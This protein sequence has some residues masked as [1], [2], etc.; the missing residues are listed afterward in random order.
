MPI[1]LGMLVLFFGYLAY[2]LFRLLRF[3]WKGLDRSLDTLV[4]PAAE[5][6]TPERKP[7][8]T[9]WRPKS[10]LI[11]SSDSPLPEPSRPLRSPELSRRTQVSE[12]QPVFLEVNAPEAAPPLTPPLTPPATAT[13]KALV[14]PSSSEE[15]SPQVTPQIVDAPQPPTAVEPS[16][17]P[18]SVSILS[19]QAAEP[20]A[21]LPL[22]PSG[23]VRDSEA[24]PALPATDLKIT[25]AALPPSETISPQVSP[26]AVIDPQPL[27]PPA[28]EPSAA[29][30]TPSIPSPPLEVAPAPPP[31]SPVS[32]PLELPLR[33]PYLQAC[34]GPGVGVV[35][36]VIGLDFGTSCT[37]V[38]VRDS[39]HRETWAVPFPGLAD[40]DNCYLLPTQV[41][42][43]GGVISLASGD[44]ALLLTDLK[45]RMLASR[46]GV[47]ATE[48]R[49][50]VA[51]YL[52]LVLLEVRKWVLTSQRRLYGRR[53]IRWSLNIGIPSAGYN[54]RR[55]REKFKSSA[56]IGWLLSRSD[57][58]VTLGEAME[59][60]R[61]KTRLTKDSGIT[62]ERIS[63]I[64]EIAA[65]VVGYARSNQRDPGLHLIV[66][67]GAGTLDVSGFKLV[68]DMDEENRYD[69]LTADVQNLGAY[70]L[71]H[72]R[73]K[74]LERHLGRP[75]HGLAASINPLTPLPPFA[76]YRAVGYQPAWDEAFRSACIRSVRRTVWYLKKTR[77]PGSR[78]WSTYLPV[79]LCGG[80]QKVDLYRQAAEAA[81]AE[82]QKGYNIA[83]F[84]VR[85]LPMPEGLDATGLPA[86]EF[87]RLAVAWGLSFKILNIGKITPP[88][89]LPD[90][91]L[92]VRHADRESE[93]VSKDQV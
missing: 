26:K 45:R 10:S 15:V 7:K 56:A 2:S 50:L 27:P 66:D 54:D 78:R 74:E 88:S 60:V 44:D 58:G 16:A 86:E 1:F 90:V 89:D 70:E 29:P 53:R 30:S 93:Y 76:A 17:T 35:D 92:E 67:V 63:V 85:P 77:D 9:G 6:S 52:G 71:H 73:V 38:V 23:P 72:H 51:A 31:V 59:M 79:F 32:A 64:P 91:K 20:T 84:Q 47:S 62:L 18:S 39:S 40:S 19:P 4:F 24:A 12:P 36:V 68:S 41:M 8:P 46:R 37:K 61:R 33:P 3:L 25:P 14:A 43:T 81:I 21:P 83:G 57:N 34:D 11:W 5:D 80:G 48:D 82:L 28:S 13:E 49:A 87:H 22:A 69:I 55:M 65:E 42:M 75:A